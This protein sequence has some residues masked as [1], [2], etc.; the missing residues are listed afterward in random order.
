MRSCFSWRHRVISTSPMRVSI[1][2]G[3][4]TSLVRVSSV[5]VISFTRS[6]A[7]LEIGARSVLFHKT[8]ASRASSGCCILTRWESASNLHHGALH[9]REYHAR[10][11]HRYRPARVDVPTSAVWPVKIGMYRRLL[12]IRSLCNLIYQANV[13]LA[14]E[15]ARRYG[16]KGLISLSV[17]PGMSCLLAHT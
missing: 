17:N 11:C 12:H 4:Q 8:A 10:Y 7:Q 14:R 15:F 1:S 3:V 16:E 6:L 2:S 13:I 9:D 5:R